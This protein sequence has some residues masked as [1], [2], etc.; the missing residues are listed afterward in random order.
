[1]CELHV[2]KVD[3]KKYKA[4]RASP[5][6]RTGLLWRVRASR[7][8]GR[9]TGC[10]AV[11]GRGLR[12]D[13]VRAHLECTPR[14]QE[15]AAPGSQGELATARESPEQPPELCAQCGAP[16]ERT[17]TTRTA[18]STVCGCEPDTPG[19][20]QK[21]P[22]LCELGGQLPPSG[23]L[24]ALPGTHGNSFSHLRPDPSGV[25]APWGRPG[26]L[27]GSI[28]PP[29]P[30]VVS[31]VGFA[32]PLPKEHAGSFKGMRF[33]ILRICIC[34]AC[35]RTRPLPSRNEGSALTCPRHGPWH[36][37]APRA[38]GCAPGRGSQVRTEVCSGL[39]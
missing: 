20:K 34:E 37:R 26:S 24:T 25:A 5:W 7:S 10:T 12:L 1:M 2:H 15:P 21:P 3:T 18:H 8:G 38:R 39:V 22:L 4:S 33:Q 36:L 35:L 6:G 11:P 23:K 9:T 13:T 16:L 30:A 32:E 27:K 14:V 17:G 28:P 31:G 29:P 19:A